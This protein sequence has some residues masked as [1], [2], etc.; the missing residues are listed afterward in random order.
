MP[1]SHAEALRIAAMVT[2]HALVRAIPN[3]GTK[4]DEN[5]EEAYS[6]GMSKRP[7]TETYE[8]LD[9]AVEAAA[10][11]SR[12]ALVEAA[13]NT[14]ALYACPGCGEGDPYRCEC[15]APCPRGL[16]GE[17]VCCGCPQACTGARR[18][19]SFLMD[20]ESI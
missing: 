3:A 18:G 13:E 17:R 19:R 7:D 4:V 16:D 20:D 14:D 1:D 9:A 15:N 10:S 6:V 8:S 11:L 12:A 2:G 5:A